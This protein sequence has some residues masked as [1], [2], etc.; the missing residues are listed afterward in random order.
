[1]HATYVHTSVL[2]RHS[3]SMR[4]QRVFFAEG[5]HGGAVVSS[6]YSDSA[7][8]KPCHQF[9]ENGFSLNGKLL[10][11][12]YNEWLDSPH[13]KEGKTCQS[14]HMPNR[15]HQWRGI[16]DPDSVKNAIKLD[17]EIRNYQETIEAEIRLT[18]QG[19]GHPFTYIFDTCDFCH[20]AITQ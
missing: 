15:R 19:A 4:L 8:C 11:N 3:R 5:H 7:F 6:A 18:N 17:V 1:M 12:T 13:A 14:C 9:E 16:H 2:V 10:E 20:C